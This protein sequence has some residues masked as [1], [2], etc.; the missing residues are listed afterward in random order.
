[1]EI[2]CH[3]IIR[4]SNCTYSPKVQISIKYS[5]L[6]TLHL[7]IQIEVEIRLSKLYFISAT[8]F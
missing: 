1:M 7:N 8:Q 4:K 6:G 2:P 5:I 3:S